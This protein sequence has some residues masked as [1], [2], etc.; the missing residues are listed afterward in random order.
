MMEFLTPAQS[1]YLIKVRVGAI[2]RAV[3]FA[4]AIVLAFAIFALEGGSRLR[5]TAAYFV[6]EVLALIALSRKLLQLGWAFALAYV[7]FTVIWLYGCWLLAMR[8]L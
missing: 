7:S 1:T 2:L 5:F 8:F 3:S 4:C 6:L